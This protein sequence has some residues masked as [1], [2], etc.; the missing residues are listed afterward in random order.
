LESPR[1]RTRSLALFVATLASMFIARGGLAALRDLD[2]ALD[3]GAYAGA[4]MAIL[5]CHELG[6]Y[7]VALRHG[8]R[9]SLPYFIPLPVG[10]GTFGAIITLRSLPASRTA[11]L[12]MGAAGPLA[13]ALVSFVMLALGLQWTGPDVPLEPGMS[14]LIFSDPWVVELLGTLVAGGAPGRYAELHPVALAG[15]VGCLLTSINLIPVGQT[16][17]GHIVSALFPRGARWVTWVVVAVLVV[18]GLLLWP[19]WAV[20]AGVILLMGAWRSLP[21]PSRPRLTLRARVLAVLAFVVLLMTFMPEPIEIEEG[22]EPV[23]GQGA[24]QPAAR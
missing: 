5:L 16:D 13:G 12:E 18:G 23:D 2:L 19:G 14:Y 24:A 4:L 3:A 21:V 17:G 20:W 6:H 22:P 10:F 8:F 1:D 9:V 11:L 7:L 15:W